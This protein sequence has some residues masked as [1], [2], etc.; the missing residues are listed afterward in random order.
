MP[1]M[2]HDLC[3]PVAQKH[4]IA[5]VWYCHGFTTLTLLFS[6]QKYWPGRT[7]AASRNG[8]TGKTWDGKRWAQAGTGN[9]M[10]MNNS[11]VLS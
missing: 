1:E 7:A 10:A 2:Y 8:A 5:I 9:P 11:P 4:G 6:I 3:Q